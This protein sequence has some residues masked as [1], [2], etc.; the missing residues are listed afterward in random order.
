MKDLPLSCPAALGWALNQTNR[1]P[2]PK[3]PGRAAGA[4]SLD[5]RP[6]VWLAEK[7]M[8]RALSCQ[9]FHRRKVEEGFAIY[10]SSNRSEGRRPT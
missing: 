1:L 8:S 3:R 2:Q 7:V 6:A 9:L 10:A 4:I 5:E